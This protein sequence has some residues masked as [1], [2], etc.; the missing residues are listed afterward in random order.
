AVRLRRRRRGGRRRHGAAARDRRATRR[1]A[2][3]GAGGRREDA[4]GPRPPPRP[5]CRPAPHRLPRLR[6]RRRVAT[7]RSRA[8]VLTFLSPILILFPSLVFPAGYFD[9]F[10]F[11]EKDMKELR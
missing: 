6:M 11:C 4:Q 8:K 10:P 5:Q 9:F 2:Q 1:G 3:L 7:R